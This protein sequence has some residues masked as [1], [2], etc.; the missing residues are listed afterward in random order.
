L[1]VHGMSNERP[2]VSIIIPCFNYARYIG[3]AIESAIAQTYENVEVIV[4]DDGSTDNSADVIG[5]YSTRVRV[6][7]QENR[8]MVP[9]WH[10]GFAASSGQIVCYLD[11]D[12][13]LEPDAAMSVATRWTKGCAKVQFDLRLIDADGRDLNRRFCHFTE[14]YDAARVRTVFRRSGTYRWPVTAGNAYSRWFLEKQ[15]PLQVTIAPEGLLNTV[16]P[17]YGE[18]ETIPRAL[19]AYRLHG[20]NS[21]SSTGDDALRL[22]ARIAHR[23]LEVSELERQAEARGIALPHGNVLDHELPF[24]NYRMLAWQLG[25]GYPGKEYDS[26]VRLL[27]AAFR[28]I[29][30]ERYAPSFAIAHGAWFATLFMAPQTVAR[31]MFFVRYKRVELGRHAKRSARA[32]GRIL[33]VEL[34]GVGS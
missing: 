31:G 26:P 19:G 17:L 33:G 6:I 9:S 34:P 14:D 13:L 1:T 16:A 18:I 28:T 22:P 30:D 32:A 10:I 15:F 21:W 25:L 4:I 20:R 24:I 7:T 11:A 27:R 8:G 3:A 23:V 5:R 2:R 12:D 29:R